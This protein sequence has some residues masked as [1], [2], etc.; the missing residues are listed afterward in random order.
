[1]VSLE[2]YKALVGQEAIDELRTLGA[3]LRGRRLKMV[4]STMV[5]GGVA[6]MLH[7]LIPLF[8]EV[9]VHAEWQV[10]EGTPDFFRVT[11]NLH[12]A[13]QGDDVEPLSARQRD[14]FLDVNRA[15]AAQLIGGEE[16]FV[17]IHD[18]QPI[19]LVDSRDKAH[20]SR[21]IWRCHIDVSRPQPRPW[22]FLRPF[23][24]RYDAAIF[25]SEAFR[26]SLSVPQHVIHPAIDPLSD[27][28]R[29]LPP[30][31]IEA[32]YARMGVPRDKPV[33]IQVSRFD[34]L[35][36]PVGVVQAYRLARAHLACR[37]VLAGG[38]ADDDPEAAAVLAD[39]R[40]EV[41]GDPDIHILADRLY[42]DVEVNA[43]VRGASLV[44]QKSL[45]EG[46]GLTVAEALW[47]RK[48]VIASNV[49]GLPLQV[50]HN[51]TGVLVASIEE[52]GAAIRA[53]LQDPG[54]MQR[55][56][57]AGRCHVRQNLLIS[58]N[59]ARW[60]RLLLSQGRVQAGARR[61]R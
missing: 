43:L 9:G 37:L 58:G 27:K 28:N 32:V 51:S 55:L 44:V 19:A 18:P 42:E 31:T 34:N 57:D 8:N 13:L 59:L 1:M 36:D 60:L 20:A 12:R 56:G 54:R 50:I 38:R 47:K 16:D 25:S 24:E 45:R 2:D 22:E 3:Q 30:A 41:D 26:H 21:W 7:R 29:E 17:V 4:N 48:A 11:K 33:V 46:F 6:E 23:M 53:L 10:I 5:G 14:L 52:T 40:R 61:A 49:G 35:K 15:N 39:V